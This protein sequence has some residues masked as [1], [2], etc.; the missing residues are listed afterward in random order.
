LQHNLK[1]YKF[2]NRKKMK[3]F[4]RITVQ[5]II[6]LT[7]A[8]F[9][10]TV[11]AQFDG[12]GTPQDPYQIKTPAD[13][14]LL[15]TKVNADADDFNAAHYKL[16][17]DLDLSAYNTGKGWTPIGKY[18]NTT[19]TSPFKGVFDGDGHRVLRL[20][21]NE[22]AADYKGLFGYI[23]GATVKNLCVVNVSI[24]GAGMIGG[25]V[26]SAKESNITHCYT[27]GTVNGFSGVGGVV[28]YLNENCSIANCYSTA[29]VSGNNIVGGVAGIAYESSVTHCY[30]T[31]VVSG[32]DVV[33][34]VVGFAGFD[35]N[36]ITDCVAL[37]YS[38]K[39]TI[40]SGAKV[41]RVVGENSGAL[42]NNAA[43]NGIVGVAPWSNIGANKLDGADMTQAAINA[44][45]SLGG[46]FKETDGWK[47]ENGALPGLFNNTVVM[48]L[49]LLP[50]N[51]VYI[52]STADQLAQLADF[53][54]AGDVNFNDKNYQLA[55]DL[56]LSD[57]GASFNGGKGWIPIGSSS[58]NPFKGVFDGNDNKITGLYINRDAYYDIGLFG[59][60]NGATIQNLGVEDVNI[61][62]GGFIGGVAGSVVYKSALSNC[63]SS[64]NVS[65]EEYVGGVAGDV[66]NS[67]LSNCYSSGN[68]N[69]EYTVGGVAGNVNNSTLSNCY[70]TCNIVGEDMIVGGVAGDVVESVVSHCY[71]I[72]NVS[73]EYSVGGVA[74][75]VSQNSALSNCYSTGE[76]SG[77]EWVG[78]VVGDIN[79]NG[80]VS[81]CAALNPSV[82]GTTDVGRVAG[83]IHSS[84]GT[85]TNNAAWDGIEGNAPW[86]N[87]GA[88]NFDGVSITKEYINTNETIGDRFTAPNGWTTQPYKLPGLLG[89]PVDMPPHLFIPLPPTIITTTLP[90]GAIGIEYTVTL[91]ATGTPTLTWELFGG[92]LPP[93]LT[94][95]TSGIISGTPTL[96]G[97]S[98]FTV[99]VTNS[100]GSATAGLSIKITATP[101][102]PVITTTTLPDGA[103]GTPYTATLEA[104]GT[105]TIIWSIEGNLPNGLNLSENG[106]ISGTP[107]TEGTFPFTVKAKNSI[108]EDSKMFTIKIGSVGIEQLGIMNYELR[109]YP[110]PTSGELRVE[111]GELRV[112][113]LEVFDVLGRKVS[114]FEFRVSGSELGAASPMSPASLNISHLPDGVYFI[115]I[116][117]ENGVVVRKVVKN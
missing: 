74:G 54:N 86:N 28:G 16:M 43:Y 117:T 3:K 50:Y 113:S 39:A 38:V 112:E 100:A 10:L 8:L 53:V 79:Y 27:T 104:S 93:G 55:N 12:S 56:D 13:L 102:P 34:G 88:D 44:D 60:I 20:Y 101:E 96:E 98:T 1:E 103:T 107:T 85:L 48:P 61:T 81:D 116:T 6:V 78:G 15:A 19:N 29:K 75:T 62:G 11:F 99:K 51:D 76:V 115:R 70:S 69:G 82:K 18:V 14:A 106:V 111:S 110:N 108:G 65:G 87:I 94:L 68:V 4:M 105:A 7:I 84:G 71:S 35:D 42:T 95:N 91:E 24:N 92:N 47:I 97:T 83:R 37:N 23:E 33:G 5:T 67:A 80:I 77:T 36:N 45:G 26:G 40:S 49:H 25:V 30:A 17:D 21:I 41:G 90:N 73:G 63:Y 52:I 32:I 46:R 64:G 114:S 2:K 109:I 9:P 22:S 57:Y 59:Y 66:Y 72:G 58:S 31:G 89:V